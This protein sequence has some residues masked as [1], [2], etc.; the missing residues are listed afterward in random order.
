MKNKLIQTNIDSFF[1]LLPVPFTKTSL[2]FHQTNPT[3]S[4]RGVHRDELSCTPEPIILYTAIGYTVH[5]DS[6]R[7]DSIH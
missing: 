2:P 1:P 3:D 6:K 7:T 5:G 4:Y